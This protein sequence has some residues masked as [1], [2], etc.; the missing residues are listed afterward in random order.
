[1]P[2]IVN[3]LRTHILI[4]NYPPFP[5]LRL[6]AT[7]LISGSIRLEFTLKP[8]RGAYH[9][10]YTAL[11]AR[12]PFSLAVGGG[13]CP[14][15]DI[16]TSLHRHTNRLTDR[17]IGPVPRTSPHMHPVAPNRVYGTN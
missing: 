9:H 12:L 17:R 10:P 14:S 4:G 6:S 3:T 2:E 16:K 11:F 5:E 1:M 15:Y 13:S 7:V 8:L